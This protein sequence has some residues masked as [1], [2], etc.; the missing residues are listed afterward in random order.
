MTHNGKVFSF[1]VF[2]DIVDIHAYLL[3]HVQ[4]FATSWTVCS[5]PVSSVHD[6]FRQEYWSGLSFLSPGNLLN[7]GIEPTS[8]VS[9]ALAAGIL[10][11]QHNLQDL[12]SSMSIFQ[13]CSPLILLYSLS[14][15]SSFIPPS[16][17]SV[18]TLLS[19][20]VYLNSAPRRGRVRISSNLST[21][22]SVR[23][24]SVPVEN[25]AVSS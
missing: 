16:I 14:I 3:S 20:I 6:I 8:P 21:F 2:C 7:P 23:R 25:P 9:P 1:Q 24:S 18:G 4:F 5:L 19:L 12:T 10:Q 11:D 22:V 13:F 15:H 17:Y